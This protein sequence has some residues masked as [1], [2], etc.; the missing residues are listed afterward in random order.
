M[1][2]FIDCIH[3]CIGASKL[4]LG[5]IDGFAHIC[6]F[7]IINTLLNEN[8]HESHHFFGH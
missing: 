1:R 7:D 8:L 6:I 5:H 2:D 4:L 3:K